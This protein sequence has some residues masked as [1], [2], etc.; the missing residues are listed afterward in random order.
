MLTEQR[1]RPSIL[2]SSPAGSAIASFASSRLPE[3]TFTTVVRFVSWPARRSLR[4]TEPVGRERRVVAA[5]GVD[6][7]LVVARGGRAALRVSVAVPVG[8][9]QE[10][11]TETTGVVPPRSA[12]WKLVNAMAGALSNVA[13]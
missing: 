12:S 11:G 3:G 2:A 5:A 6:R 7:E 8:V 10:R 4:L 13:S 1:V 9:P